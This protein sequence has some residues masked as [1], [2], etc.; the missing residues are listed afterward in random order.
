MDNL[1]KLERL[2]IIDNDFV[3]I[4]NK[5]YKIK[6]VNISA[7]TSNV[8]ITTD[9]KFVLKKI[10][11]TYTDFD[12]FKRELYLLY[13][14]NKYVDWVPKLISYDNKNNIILM[15]YCGEVL[16]NLNK[17]D[18]LKEQLNQIIY[19]LQKLNIQ[20]NDIKFDQEILVHHDKIYICDWGWG[21]IN[22]NHSC[23][24]NLWNGN[25]PYG[26]KNDNRILKLI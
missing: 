20:H 23:N 21:S 7:S 15:K 22:N 17:P 9:N 25:K 24:I 3:T 12:I 26:I 18:N 6:K 19:D 16:N 4:N 2:I 14:L 10:S 13:I 5:K 8:F 1:N 11:N